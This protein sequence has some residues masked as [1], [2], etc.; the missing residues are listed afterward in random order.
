MKMHVLSG[1]RLRMKKSVFFP[2]A[3]RAETIE[4]PVSAFLL[5]HAQGNVLFDSGCHP[6]VAD[7]VEDRWGGLTKLMMPVSKPGDN[8]IQ[9][10]HGLGMTAGD[11]DLVIAS[12]FHPDHCGCNEFFRRASVLCHPKELAAARAPESE[13]QG[14]IKADWDAAMSFDEVNGAR[15]VFGDGRIVV[16]PLPGHTPGTMGALISLDRSGSYLLASDAVSFRAFLDS[17][18]IPKNTWD[19]KQFSRSIAE[20][21]HIEKGGVTVICGH[22]D[23]QWEALKKGAN[24][25]D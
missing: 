8:V 2:D 24:A 20:I 21:R 1:G 22:D 11:I 25:Y 15:D 12:H 5:R 17:D 16:I 7:R 3:D 14:Y 6:S 23:A 10:L 18:I 4:L 19:K 13:K 9:G